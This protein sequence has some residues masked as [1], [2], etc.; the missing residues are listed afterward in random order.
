MADMPIPTLGSHVR[1]VS[2]AD[3]I[4]VLSSHENIN[5]AKA[6]ITEYLQRLAD[7]LEQNHLILNT[8]KTQVTLLTPDP[9]EYSTDLKLQL[10]GQTLDMNK[11]H[12]VLG[13]TL[14]PQA[15]LLKPN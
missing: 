6:N 10:R 4:T 9:S 5:I 3:D 2:Y 1:I 8:A 14:D 12:K 11:N 13:I 7:W 15:N